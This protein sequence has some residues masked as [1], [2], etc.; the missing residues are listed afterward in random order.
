LGAG[1]ANKSNG[2]LI[3]DNR[4]DKKNS[5]GNN[6]CDTD[7]YLSLYLQEMV[8]IPQRVASGV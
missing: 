1:V 7:G 3:G 6:H 5:K 2:F 4:G 8:I